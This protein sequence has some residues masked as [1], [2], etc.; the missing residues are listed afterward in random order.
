MHKK[1]IA[2]LIILFNVSLHTSCRIVVF[3]EKLPSF[4]LDINQKTNNNEKTSDN[5][6]NEK[7][8]TPYLLQSGDVIKDNGFFQVGEVTFL[9]SNDIFKVTNNS[10]SIVRVTCMVIGT[11]VD[12]TY[13]ILQYA[14]FGGIDQTKYK[15]DLE[16]NGWAVEHYTNMIR[17]GGTLYA[18]LS[19]SDFQYE[20]VPKPDIDNDGFYELKFMISPQSNEDVIEISLNDPVSD[21]YKLP[22]D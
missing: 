13:E 1:I 5:E 7:S 6:T 16:E 8:I 4:Y 21:M 22:V 18:T 17:P 3:P 19:I 12:G 11:K 10:E 2:I 20:G 15:K 14:G 9:H